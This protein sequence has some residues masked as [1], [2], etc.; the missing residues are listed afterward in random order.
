MHKDM[1]P[2]APDLLMGY[3]GQKVGIFVLNDD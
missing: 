3:E 1:Y 2:Y